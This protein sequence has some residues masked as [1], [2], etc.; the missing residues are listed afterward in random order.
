ELTEGVEPAVP[1]LRALRDVTRGEAQI[2]LHQ[3]DQ[4]LATTAAALERG[5][6]GVPAEFIVTLH[7]LRAQAFNERGDY[8][9]GRQAASAAIDAPGEGGAGLEGLTAFVR[10]GARMQRSLSLFKL[11]D[12]A[13][14]HRDIDAT[15]T[16]F[17]R[18]R[19]SPIL[20]ALARA[21][22]FASF[23]S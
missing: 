10:L 3:L 21:P 1:E 14:A 6:E 22:E 8:V 18:L 12:V 13:T 17:E 20:R 19:D 23:E 7:A 5:P 11:G 9:S 2:R 4:T 16:G 15:I